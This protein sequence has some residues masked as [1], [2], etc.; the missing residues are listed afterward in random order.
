MKVPQIQLN[1]MAVKW[2]NGNYKDDIETFGFKIG[3]VYKALN[4]LRIKIT[5][6][7]LLLNK[8]T[9][10]VVDKYWNAH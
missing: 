4:S 1:Q 7:Y 5:S 6:D 10:I 9:W 2:K 8:F 3:S